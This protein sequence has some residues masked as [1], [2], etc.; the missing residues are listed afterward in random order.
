M[1]FSIGFGCRD[2][3]DGLGL[4]GI[5]VVVVFHS[6]ANIQHLIHISKSDFKKDLVWVKGCIHNG[7]ILIG[8]KKYW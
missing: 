3:K 5:V 6:R 8:I 7:I 2:E 4:L 1:G